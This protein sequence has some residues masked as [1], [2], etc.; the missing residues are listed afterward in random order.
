VFRVSDIT[1][2]APRAWG[3]RVFFEGI[4]QQSPY[5]VGVFMQDLTLLPDGGRD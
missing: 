2:A 1:G 4:Y 3:E 5:K